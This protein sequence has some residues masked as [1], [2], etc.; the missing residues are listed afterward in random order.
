MHERYE[1]FPDALDALAAAVKKSGFSLDEYSIVLTPDRYTLQTERALFKGAGSLNTEVL[2]LSRL[3]RRV[4]GSGRILTREGGVM[5]VAKATAEVADEL[6]YYKHATRYTDFAREVYETLL[7]ISSSC[8]EID[9]L[10]E[11]ASGATAEK[12]HDLAIINARYEELKSGLVDSPDRLKDLMSAAADSALVKSARIYAI[13]YK[14]V[15]KLNRDVFEAL[16]RSAKAFTLYDADP[17]VPRKTMAVYAAPDGVSQYKRIAVDIKEYVR[18]GGRYGDIAIVSATGSRALSRILG[19]YGIRYYSDSTT[20]LFDTPPLAALYALYRL[21]SGGDATVAAAFAKNPFSGCDREDAERL[22]LELGARGLDFLS[23]EFVPDNKQAARALLKVRAACGVFRAQKSFADAAEKTLE[24]L[25]FGSNPHRSYEGVTDL[26]EPIERLIELLRRYGSGAFDQDAGMFFAA[27]RAVAVSSLPGYTDTVNVCAASSLRMTRCKRLYIPD[28]NEG[29]LPQ[30]VSDTGLLSDAELGAMHGAVEPTVREKNRRD[31][32]ELAA[33]ISNADAVFCSYSESGGARISAFIYECCEKPEMY[34][35]NEELAMLKATDSAEAIARY[36]CT[37]GAA[38][39]IAARGMSKKK[40]SIAAATERSSVTSPPS[41]PY[42][43]LTRRSLSVSE[44]KH[45]FDCPYKRFLTDSVGLKE[46][47]RASA[48]AADFGIVMH[49]FM[50]RWIMTE[51]LDASKEAVEK[52]TNAVLDDAGLF[53]GESGKA[54]RRRIASDAA[55]FAA[56]NK[57]IIEAGSYVPDASRLE[58]PFGGSI[59]LGKAAL[60]FVG[61]IDRVDRNG[62]DVRVIDYKTGSTEFDV[63]DSLCGLDMQLPLYAATL[64]AGGERVTGAFYVALKPT[65]A[66]DAT[67]VSGCMVKDVSV[68][69]DYDAALV[70]GERSG[71][72]PLRLRVKDGAP[73]GFW[74]GGGWLMDE[75]DFDGFVSGCVATAGLAADEICSGYIEKSPVPRACLRCKYGA[76]CRDKKMRGG[77]IEEEQ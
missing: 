56:I 40:L 1:N 12:L 5:L 21:K 69:L 51:P 74:G 32:D 46:R 64:R 2:T 15:T 49:E 68:A 75:S 59:T 22:D 13:G 52:I 44:L 54:D 47:R 38:R 24:A 16:A 35:L 76:L 31:R 30:T 43:A 53:T 20:S 66:S 36:A 63:K 70:N 33:V 23:S 25:D 67:C 37:A 45:Y 60:P 10:A 4:L 71:V 9:K 77:E 65:Y 29:V 6:T 8:A 14:D 41:E 27:A 18:K 42:V 58:T 57:K 72:M 7:Q 3:A 50:R 11:N 34:D 19:E 62:D 28:F 26:I 17:P 55:D 61:V 48:S 39:E 73:T